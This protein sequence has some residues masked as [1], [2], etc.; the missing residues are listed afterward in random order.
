MLQSL[1]EAVSVPESIYQWELVEGIM[2][3]YELITNALLEKLRSDLHPYASL[4]STGSGKPTSSSS[5]SRTGNIVAQLGAPSATNSSVCV[6]VNASIINGLLT[7]PPKSMAAA[8]VRSGR[9]DTA[10]TALEAFA[11]PETSPWMKS[12]STGAHAH[13]STFLHGTIG[14]GN[15]TVSGIGATGSRSGSFELRMPS[16][17]SFIAS[18]LL[19]DRLIPCWYTASSTRCRTLLYSTEVYFTLLYSTLL[20]LCPTPLLC[21]TLHFSTLL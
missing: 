16:Q 8:A 11:V 18:I 2:L 13:T 10:I 7:P 3:S 1:T 6:S 20:F 4:A 12:P 5:K 9:I 21:T 17:Q 14:N 15:G 19:D